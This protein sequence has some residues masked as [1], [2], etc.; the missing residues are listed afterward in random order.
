M[1][2]GEN[3]LHRP[4]TTF[5]G[6]DLGG[7]R[8]KTTAVAT[9]TRRDDGVA[10]DA[11]ATRR[12]G[13]PWHDESLW[14]YLSSLGSSA[15]IAIN[16]PLTAPACV[17]CVEAICPGIAECVDPA[18]VWLRTVGHELAVGTEMEQAEVGAPAHHRVTTLRRTPRGRVV[19]YSQRG[20]ELVLCHE[21][22][23]LPQTA[24]GGA[25]G[26]VA[27]R[28]AHLVKRLAAGGFA[29]HER[30]IEV[31]AHATVA[32][33]FDRRKARGYKRDADPWH[34]RA[35]IVEGLAAHG[36]LAFSPSSRMSREEVLRNDN[37]FDA[38]IAG[39]TAYRWTV[40]GWT[41][42]DPVFATDGWIYAPAPKR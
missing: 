33:L 11:V 30:L 12:V 5:V 25:T 4:F 37:C 18:V 42:P 6:I 10:V 28:A 20:T 29:M 24:I 34:T 35:E 41:L 13:E 32:A 14:D 3:T 15:A 38:M 2:Q 22:G 36:G 16:A 19:P 39:Y 26:A 31:S 27:A 8:G 40:E 21:Q 9:L 23:I 1:V 7:A 17:R